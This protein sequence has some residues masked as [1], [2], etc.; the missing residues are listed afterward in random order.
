MTLHRKQ[1]TTPEE[2]AVLTVNG[3]QE[4]LI[5]LVDIT[6]MVTEKDQSNAA[7]DVRVIIEKDPETFS[8]RVT[9]ACFGD[10][11]TS[12]TAASD[13]GTS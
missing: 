3:G 5:A 7:R 10:L 4:Q 8:H 1:A 12:S 13:R 2:K 9:K 11:E 6:R